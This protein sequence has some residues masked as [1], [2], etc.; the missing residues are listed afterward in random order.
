MP[1]VIAA[2][3]AI[4]SLIGLAVAVVATLRAEAHQ[5]AGT[6]ASFTYRAYSA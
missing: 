5:G 2:A 3:F 6:A 1:F 4:V